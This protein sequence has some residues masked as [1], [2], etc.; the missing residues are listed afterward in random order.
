MVTMRKSYR[1]YTKGKENRIKT[2]HYKKLIRYKMIVMQEMRDKKTT[3]YR[4]NQQNDRS[5]LLLAIN[6]NANVLNTQIKRQ[7]GKWTKIHHPTVYCIQETHFKS[8][9]IHGLKVRRLKKDFMQIVTKRE[10]G[11]LY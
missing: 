1:T 7:I 3:R 6:L 9:D 2:F 5:L 8:S 10:Q 4:E 11:Q